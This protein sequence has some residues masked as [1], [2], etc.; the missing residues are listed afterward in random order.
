MRRLALH[1]GASPGKQRTEKDPWETHQLVLPCE[2]GSPARSK[3]Q[4]PMGDTETNNQ[5][6]REEHPRE[7]EHVD[8]EAELQR[9]VTNLTEQFQANE[10]RVEESA[11]TAGLAERRAVEA[12]QK[13]DE[14]EGQLAEQRTA[15]E[16]CQNDETCRDGGGGLEVVELEHALKESR[17]RLEETDSEVRRL[18]RQL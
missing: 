1:L 5:R 11:E 14:L 17:K 13:I 15:A 3:R 16:A 4:S 8:R 2:D 18:Q 6:L 7:S 9:E 10:R 12:E